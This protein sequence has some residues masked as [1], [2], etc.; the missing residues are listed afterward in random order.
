MT[1]ITK[2]PQALLIVFSALCSFGIFSPS[3]ATDW[4]PLPEL[5]QSQSAVKNDH[6]GVSWQV[7]PESKNMIND[8]NGADWVPVAQF[9]KQVDPIIWTVVTDEID[10]DLNDKDGSGLAD[11]GKTPTETTP[12]P[13]KY[14]Q[15]QPLTGGL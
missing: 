5:P 1:R 15:I 6:L 7:V 3:S 10:L 13:Y 9:S 11:K 2:C 12:I 14:D 4:Q 8:P